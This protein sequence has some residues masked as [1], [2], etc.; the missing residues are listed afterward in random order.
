MNLIKKFICKI[1]GCTY[2]NPVGIVKDGKP[3]H[4]ITKCQR[5]GEPFK[6]D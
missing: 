6:N 5:C 1:F 2:K 3:P 4:F